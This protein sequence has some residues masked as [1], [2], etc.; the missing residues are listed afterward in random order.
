MSDARPLLVNQHARVFPGYSH[1]FAY[2]S[3]Y[4]YLQIQIPQVDITEIIFP[5][6][7]LF[8]LE[9]LENLEK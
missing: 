2:S 1:K 8:S 5:V 7:A 3:S 9:N 4:K 6:W